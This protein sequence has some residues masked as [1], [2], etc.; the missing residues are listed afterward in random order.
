[1]TFF[2]PPFFFNEHWQEKYVLT[3]CEPK[4]KRLFTREM[5][6]L[7]QTAEGVR[8]YGEGLRK[9]ERERKREKEGVGRELNSGVFF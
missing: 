5:Q 6:T 8:N 3:V 2:F 9:E 1:M 7:Q 4:E